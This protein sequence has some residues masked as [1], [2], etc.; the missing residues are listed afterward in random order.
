MDSVTF[1]LYPE[2]ILHECETKHDT[3]FFVKKDTMYIPADA[4]P[5]V[6]TTA[7]T[8]ATYNSLALGGKVVFGDHDAI[9]E[10]GICYATHSAPTIADQ[11]ARAG[12]GTGTFSITITGLTEKTH[13]DLHAYAFH[14]T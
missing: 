4:S 3:V 8:Q 11:V 1:L 9:T 5:T 7:V 12:K 13:Y 10:R 14:N 6:T 2:G